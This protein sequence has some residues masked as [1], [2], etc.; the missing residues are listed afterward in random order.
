MIR[1]CH[2]CNHLKVN[3]DLQYDRY[4]CGFIYKSWEEAKKNKDFYKG[5][6]L[7]L[8]IIGCP[9]L[10]G[11]FLEPGEKLFIK[12]YVMAK[13]MPKYQKIIKLPMSLNQLSQHCKKMI[14][15][16]RHTEAHKTVLILIK[17]I[18]ENKILK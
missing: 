11:I 3:S 8:Q 1:H 12:S 9:E 17:L 10:T 18:K 6:N 14:K 7:D 16:N 5:D 15:I 2:L 4:Y 13:D